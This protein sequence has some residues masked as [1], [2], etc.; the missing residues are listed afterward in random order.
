M[1]PAMLER[2]R[3]AADKLALG[4]V[5]LRPGD[6]TALPLE[7]AS[8]DVVLSN[9]VL[10]LI[11]EKDA[12]LKEIRRVLKPGGRAQIADIALETELSEDARS[13]IDLWTG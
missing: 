2:A 10:N 11:P 4:Q 9:G 12:A 6:A 3:Q 1:T 13:D 8:V 5:E 7:D